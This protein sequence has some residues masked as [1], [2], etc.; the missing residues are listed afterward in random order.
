MTIKTKAE[1]LIKKYKKLL[2]LHGWKFIIVISEKGM[3]ESAALTYDEREKEAQVLINKNINIESDELEN[4]I[5]HELTHLFLLPYTSYAD[6][7]LNFI[8]ENP[9]NIKKLNF[10]K[11]F[12]NLDKIEEKLVIKLIQIIE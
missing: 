5:K 9:D 6:T 3:E 8:N 1:R 7:I 2:K 11:I 4:T 12:R 10:K